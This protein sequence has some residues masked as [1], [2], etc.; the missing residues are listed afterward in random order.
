MSVSVTE[1]TATSFVILSDI[2]LSDT[3]LTTSTNKQFEIA[4]FGGANLICQTT[5]G[6]ERDGT[7]VLLLK[8]CNAHGSCRPLN[9]HQFNIFY[10][11][12]SKI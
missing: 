8:A 9:I 1:L 7:S 6:L 5:K 10:R 4:L 11:S 12:S 3:K 2:R